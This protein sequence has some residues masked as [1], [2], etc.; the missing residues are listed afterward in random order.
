[1]SGSE[2]IALTEIEKLKFAKVDSGVAPIDHRSS[3]E[4]RQRQAVEQ[5][6]S[7]LAEEKKSHDATKQQLLELQKMFLESSS[8]PT[9]SSSEPGLGLALGLGLVP[10]YRVL[11]EGWVTRAMK[12]SAVNRSM[13]S[14]WSKCYAVLVQASVG[15]DY[16]AFFAGAEVR[17][18]EPL[19]CGR[20]LS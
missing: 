3:E 19:S 2:S 18:L 13:F 9:K 11:V 4:S 17:E 12:S 10:G 8:L 5:L 1:M 14:L 15:C 7:L 20:I 16:I 6:E